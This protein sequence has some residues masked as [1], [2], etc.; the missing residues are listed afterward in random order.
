LPQQLVAQRRLAAAAF[1]ACALSRLHTSPPQTLSFIPMIFRV[2]ARQ[3]LHREHHAGQQQGWRQE[4]GLVLD[5]LRSPCH[6]SN[7]R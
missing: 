6:A 7:H 1:Q 3:G 5:R 2:Q 4:V